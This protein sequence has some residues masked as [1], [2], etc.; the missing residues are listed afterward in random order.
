MLASP[1]L[2]GHTLES[3]QASH[4]SPW[5]VTPCKHLS[6]PPASPLGEAFP[7]SFQQ[8]AT[9][10]GAQST[11]PVFLPAALTEGMYP[12]QGWSQLLCV[13]LSC[14]T[15]PR[16]GAGR[17]LTANNYRQGHH[18]E[19]AELSSWSPGQGALR[20][21]FDSAAFWRVSGGFEGLRLSQ[22]HSFIYP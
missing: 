4:Y 3:F 6:F 20:A 12:A 5:N 15:L 14:H 22:P 10:P 16:M 11:A 8:S 2:R 7:A 17:L 18:G 19:T 21:G 9:C 13:P 1:S